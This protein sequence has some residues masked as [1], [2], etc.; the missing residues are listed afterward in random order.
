MDSSLSLQLYQLLWSF[1]ILL[2]RHIPFCFW[3]LTYTVPSAQNTFPPAQW[4]V[5]SCEFFQRFSL[6]LLLQGSLPWVPSG[7]VFSNVLSHSE[8]LPSNKYFRNQIYLIQNCAPGP[9]TELS[10]IWINNVYSLS[11]Q[12]KGSNY[13]HQWKNEESRFVLCITSQWTIG[14]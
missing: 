6:M 3:A 1:V 11:E 12:M 7:F 14:L 2:P 8:I 10:G 4:L 13:S 5:N 9:T